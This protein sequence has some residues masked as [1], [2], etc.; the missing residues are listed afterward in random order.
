MND[1]KKKARRLSI[2]TLAHMAIEK[3]QK[4]KK[5]EKLSKKLKTINKNIQSI[6]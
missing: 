3:K 4:P 5:Y 1:E 2:V 6:C